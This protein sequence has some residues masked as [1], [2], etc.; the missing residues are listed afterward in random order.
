MAGLLEK[1]KFYNRMVFMNRRSTVIMFLG[2]AI[3][4]AIISE[5]LIFMYSFQYGAF[6]GFY[7]GVPTRQF[8]ISVSSYDIRDYPESSIPNLTLATSNSIENAEISDR[9]KRVDWFL[10]RGFFLVAK[11]LRTGTDVILPEFNLYAIPTDYFSAINEMLYNGTLP[12]NVDQVIVVTSESTLT[13]TNLSYVGKF[14]AYTPIFGYEYTDVIDLGIPL[15]GQYFNSSGSITYETFSSVMGPLADDFNAMIDYFSEQFMITSYT[16]FANLVAKFS[17]YP[18]YSAATGRVAFNLDLI[19][20]FNIANEIS[21]LQRFS[22]E[23]DREFSQK[24]FQVVIYTS[25]ITLL[26]D[27]NKEFLIFQ[28]FGLLLI[29]PIIGMSLSLTNYSANLM[30]RRQKRQISSMLQRGSSQKEVLYV[31]IFQVVELSITAILLSAIIGYGFSWLINKSTGFLNFSGT[32]VYPTINMTIFYIIIGFGFILSLIV[33]AKNIWDT[34]QITTFE[35]YTEHQAKKPFWEGLYLDVVL[36][37]L[38]LVI[39]LIVRFQLKGES[40]YA[41]AYG[42]GTT[43]PVLIILGMVMMASYRIYPRLINYISN[44]A[45]RS[46]RLGILGLASRRS[47]RRKIDATRSIILISLTFTLIFTSIIT[48]QSYQN[49]DMETA[50]YTLGADILLRNV[51]VNSNQ[52]K[53]NV[54]SIEGVQSATYLKMTSQLITYGFL[55]YSYIVLGIDPVE[56]VQTAYFERQYLQG[57]NPENFFEK[58]RDDNDV[59]MQ[60]DQLAIIDTYSGDQLSIRFEK[61]AVGT[62]NRTLDVVGIY[63]YFPRFFVEFPDIEKSTVF[64]FTIVGSYDNVNEFAYSDFSIGGDLIVKV[65]DGYNIADVATNIET[66]LGRS[67]ESNIDLMGSK[68]GSL[69]NIMLYGSLNATFLASLILTISTI[70]LMILIQVFENE[71]E[72]VTLKILGMSPR[73][74]FNLFLSESMTVVLYGSIQGIGIGI[75]AA[76]MFT[77]ILTFDTLIPPTKMIFPPLQLSLASIIFLIVSLLTAALTSYIV[78]RKDAI[79]AI[80]QI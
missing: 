12:Q 57:E 74:L 20:S 26:K 22:Q 37:V 29:T 43:A 33:N 9:I 53:L 30:K 51:D 16:N 41:F 77:K 76:S 1:I 66:E 28:L 21:N 65:K 73:Q 67:V 36:I 15:G 58:I 31:L 45:W 79:K 2:L 13:R 14:A 34:S 7:Q 27:F 24:D 64:R 72:V 49:H 54:L 18:G 39:W 17:Y 46:K 47:M 44:R 60:R 38:G 35:A 10:S 62:V 50:N 3:S 40:A 6:E 8:T 68:E 11:N 78:F 71:R 59:V 63:K 23:I 32:S 69:R 61:Y 52:T 75:I 48:I 4:L 56:F 80:K 70:A 5:S 55:T 42:I 25:L 19:N